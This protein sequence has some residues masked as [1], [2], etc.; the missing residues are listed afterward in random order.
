[1]DGG[2]QVKRLLCLIGLHRFTY[3]SVPFR[4]GFTAHQRRECQDCG[5]IQQREVGWVD[6]EN[7]EGLRPGEAR[8]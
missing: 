2:A 4:F 5:A 6:E 1:M 3:W 8:R 7:D